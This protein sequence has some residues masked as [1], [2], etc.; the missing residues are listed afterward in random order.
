M[1]YWQSRKLSSKKFKRLY[2]VKP[3]TFRV[4]FR[5]VKTQEKQN[6]KSGLPAKLIIENILIKSRQFI[7]RVD[8]KIVTGSWA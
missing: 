6:K 1:K 5:L 4:M 8:I 7:C 3:Q 2:G